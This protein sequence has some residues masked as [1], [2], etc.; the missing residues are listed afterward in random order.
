LVKCRFAVKFKVRA[1]P[2]NWME[3]KRQGN[4]RYLFNN[5]KVIPRF[6]FTI[7]IIK[8]NIWVHTTLIDLWCMPNFFLSK[9]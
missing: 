9:I 1:Y 3:H 7:N 8:A 6:Q 2:S 4:Y 5:I